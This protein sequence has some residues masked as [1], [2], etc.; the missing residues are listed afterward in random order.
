MITWGISA[1]SHDAALAVFQNEQLV[2]ASHSERFS[3]VKNDAH[4]CAKLIDYAKT[5]GEPDHI[6]WYEKPLL[7]TARQLYAG[8]GWNYTEN[9]VK[10]YLESHYVNAPVS[11][12]KHHYSHASAGYYTS[13]YKDACV[14]VIDAIGEFE[15]ITVWQGQ[16]KK[17]KKVYSQQYPHSIGLW[18]S[19]MTQR[20]GLKPNEDEYILMGLSAF[21]DPD[22]LYESVRNDFIKD[23]TSAE[24]KSNLHRG[25]QNWRKDLTEKDYPDIAAA[26]QKVYEELLDHM[27]RLAKRLVPYDN[28]VLMGGCALNCA[29]NIRAFD[30]FDNVW[31]MPN[32]GDAGSSIGAV[33]AHWQ[34]HISWHGP[35]LGF[36][37]V[38]SHSNQDIVRHLLKNPVCGVARGPAEFG[39]RALGNRSLL[40]DP[41][42]PDIKDEL[43][44]IKQR[45][46]YRPFAPVVLAEHADSIFEMPAKEIPYMQYAVKCKLPDLYPGIVHVDGTSRVQTVTK[47]QNSNLYNLL[48]RWYNETG[49]PLLVNTS[50][51]IKGEPMVN[52]QI[53]VRRFEQK[54]NIKIF[55]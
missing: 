14:L 51:N 32:P 4:L 15:T 33:L 10:R 16:G 27:L 24:F 52:D 45:Q 39:P 38:Q 17:L 29:A 44:K 42:L 23:F 9:N 40:A 20:I 41:R 5:W 55:S 48:T 49:C 35:Y 21:G 3:R 28:L 12:S 53:D 6:C 22:R 30:Y 37:I 2:F 46:E 50:L 1:N 18:Y 13:G 34:E 7:K 26:T 11:Y 8:Q 54:Y 25:C 36:D 31:I 47:E 43:N 19:A